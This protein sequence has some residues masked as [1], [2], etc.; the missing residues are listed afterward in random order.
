MKKLDEKK[1]EIISHKVKA[2]MGGGKSRCK[3]KKEE[4]KGS[5]DDMKGPHVCVFLCTEAPGFCSDKERNERKQTHAQ[6]N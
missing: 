6:L 2:Q 5:R 4:K 1:S 3:G